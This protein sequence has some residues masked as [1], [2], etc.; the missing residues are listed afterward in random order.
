MELE[1]IKAKVLGQ[2]PDAKCDTC[3]HNGYIVYLMTSE[4][5]GWDDSELEAWYNFYYKYCEKE[6]VTIENIRKEIDS[7]PEEELKNMWN[8]VINQKFD[9]PKA[10]DF[11]I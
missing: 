6:E 10:I 5:G 1:E 3:K 2:F 9:S 8:N 4:N 11:K 7:I